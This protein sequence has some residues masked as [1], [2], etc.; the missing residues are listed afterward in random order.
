MHLW[1]LGLQCFLAVP[2]PAP[3]GEVVDGG[4]LNERRED[5]GVAHGDEPVHGGG[6]RHLGQRVPCADA[7]RCH[8]EHCSDAC[9][10][11]QTNK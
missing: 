11:Q 8:G 5:K 7:Q 9:P 2:G 6:V 3:L 10:N 1:V 4:E